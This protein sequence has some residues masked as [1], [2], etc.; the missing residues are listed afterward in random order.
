ME[1]RRRSTLHMAERKIDMKGHKVKISAFESQV[2]F[3]PGDMADSIE[4]AKAIAEELAM[5]GDLEFHGLSVEY[6]IPDDGENISDDI[7]I[8][9]PN[10]CCGSLCKDAGPHSCLYEDPKTGCVCTLPANHEG[11]H[12]ACSNGS[13]NLAMWR[14]DEKTE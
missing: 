7:V 9:G 8:A 3:I 12:I 13:H 11:G 5:N 2:Y 6:V 14:R 10:R 4:D 1:G